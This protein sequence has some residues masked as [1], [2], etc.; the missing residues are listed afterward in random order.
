MESFP[1]FQERERETQGAWDLDSIYRP[2]ILIAKNA[3]YE[4][5]EERKPI[6]RG[7]KKF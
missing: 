3:C 5:D 1:H 2:L 4:K 6:H 7:K